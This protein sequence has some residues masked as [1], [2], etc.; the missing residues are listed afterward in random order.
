MKKQQSGFTLIELMIVVA[1]IGI[2]AAVAIPAYRDYVAE[3]HGGAAMKGTSG[4]IQKVQA[5]VQTGIGCTSLNQEIGVVTQITSSNDVAIDT[6]YSL[7]WD[8]G[9]CEITA[10]VTQNG[11]VTYTANNTGTGATKVQCESGAGL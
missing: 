5:C 2:L 10:A 1:I 6:A 9:D 3:S 4:F 8:D 11:L 7:V